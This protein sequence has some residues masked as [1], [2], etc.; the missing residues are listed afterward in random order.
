MDEEIKDPAVAEASADDKSLA[1]QAGVAKEENNEL[2]ECQKMRDEYLNNWKRAV[3]DLSN[4]KK[5]EM[6]RM[7]N[8]LGYAKEGMFENILPVIDSI[9][10]ASQAFGKDGFL[11]I[12]KQIEEFL[13]KE[14]IEALEV[15]GKK[16]DAEIMEIVSEEEGGESGMVLEELQKGYKMND[17]VIRVAKVKVSK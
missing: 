14:G 1:R 2:V 5:E 6:A 4:Y 8:L 16:F 17:K 7:G 12:Q 3:A 11:P 9:Y 15:T 10:L 13:K